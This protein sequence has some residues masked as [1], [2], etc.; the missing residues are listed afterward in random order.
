MPALVFVELDFTDERR[1]AAVCRE[2]RQGIRRALRVGA[3][4]ELLQR[5]LEFGVRPLPAV[6]PV[7]ACLC[8]LLKDD[9]PLELSARIGGIL[10][11]R[12]FTAAPPDPAQRLL[13]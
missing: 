9:R 4:D 10:L 2:L 11:A 5:L 13:A 7:G 3:V 1:L 8:Q 6:K 12:S